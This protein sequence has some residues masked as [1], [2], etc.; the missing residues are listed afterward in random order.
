MSETEGHEMRFGEGRISAALS[1]VAVLCFHF[2]EYLTTPELRAAY[3][4]DLLRHLLRVGMSLAIVFGALAIFLS[5]SMRLGFAGIATTLLAQ[6]MAR[7][8]KRLRR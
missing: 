3:P 1:L 2:P 6:S 8:G 7:R 5:R 4:V